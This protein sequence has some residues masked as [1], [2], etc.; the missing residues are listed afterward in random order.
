MALSTCLDETSKPFEAAP[1]SHAIACRSHG[2]GRFE[3]C[4]ASI[5]RGSVP[6]Q[7]RFNLK[8]GTNTC[9][10]EFP[11]YW[12]FFIK[13][14][15]TT[16]VCSAEAANV[17]KNVMDEIEQT[18]S[19]DRHAAVANEAAKRYK[20][21]HAAGIRAP[22]PTP[23]PL[24]ALARFSKAHSRSF[25]TPTM[26]TPCSSTRRSTRCRSPSLRG[27]AFLALFVDGCAHAV[28][29]WNEAPHSRGLFSRLLAVRS[30]AAAASD[31]PLAVRASVGAQKSFPRPC[32][33][34][35]LRAPRR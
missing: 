20:I 12:N 30:A 6:V 8:F 23:R 27:S 3:P 5:L 1:R 26:S 18:G 29:K 22:P 7:E 14:S 9:E 24:C 25:S 33:G 28:A 10:T 34:H 19:S 2:A 13:G 31:A 15:T 4:V 35:C 17:I 16:L 32:D 11:A 21:A